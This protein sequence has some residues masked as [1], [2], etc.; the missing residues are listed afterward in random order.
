MRFGNLSLPRGPL[1]CRREV[2]ETEGGMNALRLLSAGVIVCVLSLGVRADDKKDYSKQVIGVWEVVKADPDSLP[3]GAVVDMAK[4]GKLKV[5]MKE[6]KK[7]VTHEGTYK[8]DGDKIMVTLK[9]NDQEIKHTVTIKKISD[10]EM[11]TEHDG[12]TVQFK[13]KTTK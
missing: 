13:K 1:W 6:D 10:T 5:T 3:V 8:L 4:D 7:E 2:L 9:M 12:K 11:T